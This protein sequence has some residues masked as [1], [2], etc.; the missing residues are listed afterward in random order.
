MD[1][2]VEGFSGGDRLTLDL[3]KVQEDLL[4]AMESL[5]KP[6]V[7]VLL[8]GSAVAVNWADAHIPAIVEAWY[9]GEEAGNAIAD[10]IFGNYNPGGRLP[11][12]FYRSVDQL[13]P[14]EDY[15]MAG[16]TYRYSQQAPLYPFG[17]G[18]SYTRFAYSGLML[19]KQQIRGGDSVRCHRD[20]EEH[21]RGRRG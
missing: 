12:T 17:H 4:R 3:P 5:K 16:R 2:Q 8:N 6:I 10:V 14:F 9:P 1:V 7:V 19:D 11:V 15:R 20:G 18:L 13:P 21:R